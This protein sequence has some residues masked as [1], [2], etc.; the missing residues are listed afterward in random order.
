MQVDVTESYQYLSS[1]VLLAFQWLHSSSGW[2]AHHVAK[3]DDD[4]FIC[5]GR[6]LK[7][8]QKLPLK[9]LFAGSFHASGASNEIQLTNPSGRWFNPQHAAMFS[10]KSYAPFM[11][12]GFYLLSW[13]NVGLLTTE[14]RRNKLFELAKV[15]PQ[16]IPPN[17]DT[18]VA[19]LL[20]RAKPH[21]GQQP[22][23]DSALPSQNRR[24]AGKIQYANFNARQPWPLHIQAFEDKQSLLAVRF[25]FDQIQF[26]NFCS[27]PTTIAIHPASHLWWQKLCMCVVSDCK[28]DCTTI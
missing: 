25:A 13:D 2:K 20:F 7:T 3:S 21:E 18:L 15:A 9:G 16:T 26:C 8:L 27:W 14:A 6:L 19:E 22:N 4:T 23:R 10:T 17:E 24:T 28:N 12:G 11:E 1:K 5:V